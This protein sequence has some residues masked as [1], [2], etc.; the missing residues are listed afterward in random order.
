MT[1]EVKKKQ[2]VSSNKKNLFD[3]VEKSQNQQK[4]GLK[5]Y[6]LIMSGQ[7]QLKSSVTESVLFK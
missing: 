5:Q 2:F 7:K 4:S 1:P 6:D 3:S